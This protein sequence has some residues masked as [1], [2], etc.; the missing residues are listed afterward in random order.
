LLGVQLPPAVQLLHVPPLHTLLIPHEVPFITFPVS[1][2]TDV[3][4]AHEVAPVR[5]AAAGVQVTPAVHE[6]Q[7]PPLQTLFVPQE[8]PFVTFPLSTQ[9]DVPVAHEI[10]PV[11]HAVAGVQAA[12]AVQEPQMPPLQ[13]LLVPQEVP[14]ATFP[15]STQADIP[16]TQEVAPVRH[17]VAGVHAAAAVQAPHVPLLHTMFVP[18]TV[19]L[20][21]LLPVSTQSMLG[22]QTICPA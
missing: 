8:V 19:P 2:Q 11:R 17:A 16:V 13:T 3:P 10:A 14:F 15:V 7:V 5:H 6:T 18:H 22:E 1:A 21:R 9:T 12:P 4:V 20:T